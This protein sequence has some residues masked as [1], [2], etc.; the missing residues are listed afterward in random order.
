MTRPFAAVVRFPGSNCEYETVRALCAAG[1]DGRVVH[2]R[3][4]MSE[5][6][7][8][9]VIVLPGGFS[10]EDRLRAGA[11]AAREPFVETIVARA[12]SGTP[13]LGICNGA[14]VLTET[15]LVP[16]VRPGGIDIALAENTVD[17]VPDGFLCRWTD[18]RVHASERTRLWTSAMTNGER[19]PWPFAHGEGRF[20]TSDQNVLRALRDYD[21]VTFSFADDPAPNGAQLGA[22][23]IVNMRGNVLAV[24]PHPER[25]AWLWHVAWDVRGP[26]GDAR[27]RMA[28][29]SETRDAH[30][31]G[32]GVFASLAAAFDVVPA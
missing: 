15:G 32:W 25:A 22:A 23:G 3:D 8:A 10:F 7:R 5:V 1:F 6:A 2:W 30:G 28:A 29:Q 27:R 14:Q 31:P 4:A 12:E 11:I 20:L 18:V 26:W 21:L 19:L 16:G 24:M 17:G 9:D 13:V